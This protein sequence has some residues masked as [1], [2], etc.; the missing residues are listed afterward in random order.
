MRTSDILDQELLLL[1]EGVSDKDTWNE[2]LKKSEI[3]HKCTAVDIGGFGKVKFY[4]NMTLLECRRTKPTVCT[5]LD[6]DVRS[7][8]GG[9][10]AIRIAK[11]LASQY[12]R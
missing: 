7:K 5:A 6:G 3:H 10:D 11:N 8:P 12:K 1:V 4:A 9:E 2:W